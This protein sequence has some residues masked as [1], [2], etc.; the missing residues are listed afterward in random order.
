M[1]KKTRV[2]TVSGLREDLSLFTVSPAFEKSLS[3]GAEVAGI[4]SRDFVTSA[5]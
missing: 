2:L 3:A 1:F 4:Q 5:R